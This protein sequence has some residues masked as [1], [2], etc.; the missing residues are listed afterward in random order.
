MTD[1][2]THG[3]LHLLTQTLRA[4]PAQLADLTRLGADDL[5]ALRERLSS[6]LFDADE[7]VFA[8]L[9]KLAPLVPNAL[10]VKIAVAVVPPEVAG[11]AGG[12]LG[13]AHPDRIADVLTALPAP[14]LAD[15]APHMDPRTVAALAP[16][17]TGAML[18][19]T[20]VEL[21]RRQNYPTAGRFVEFA[22]DALVDDLEQGIADDIGLLRTVA[23]IPDAGRL[24]AVVRR[25]PIAR[26][27]TIIR[28]AAPATDETLPATL[29]VLARL[30]DDL[31]AHLAT[32]LIDSLDADQLRGFVSAAVDH[33][34]LAELFTVLAATGPE[35]RDRVAELLE[36]AP[37]LATALTD[38]AAAADLRGSLDELRALRS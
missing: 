37:E 15:S 4:E 11:R 30:G 1:L 31:R 9:S 19:P 18:I 38:A 34:A 22:T 10:L 8:R 36:S 29:S 14:Y 24:D 13:L 3:Q 35:R 7:P 6:L 25:L 21:L 5:R 20:A 28:A 32:T 16:R 17:L 33:G 26:C 23:I 12:S 2:L 27:E